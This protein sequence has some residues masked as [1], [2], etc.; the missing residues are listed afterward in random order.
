MLRTQRSQINT[1]TESVYCGPY[2][3]ILY[4]LPSCVVPLKL[5]SG[6]S[7]NSFL[8]EIRDGVLSRQMYSEMFWLSLYTESN[9][10]YA[11]FRV[12]C[13]RIRRSLFAGL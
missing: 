12:F 1:Y 5:G 7:L 9:G 10:M 11:N 3:V 4:C 13:I 8:K 6:R 2:I